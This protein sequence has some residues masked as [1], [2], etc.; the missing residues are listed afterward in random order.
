LHRIPGI[1]PVRR[2]LEEISRYFKFP[3]A[4]VSVGRNPPS[5]FAEK[6]NMVNAVSCPTPLGI[7]PELY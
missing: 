3:S 5:S 7:V 2:E 1:V 4:P 6:D